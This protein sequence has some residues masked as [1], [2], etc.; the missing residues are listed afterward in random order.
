MKT[1]HIISAAVLAAAVTGCADNSKGVPVPVPGSLAQN[2]SATLRQANVNG[3]VIIRQ[4]IALPPEAVL[5][6]TLSDASVADAPSKVLAQR[7]V[8]TDGK[9]SPFQFL[10]PYSP[11][12]IKPGARI[13][14]SAAVTLN[15]KMLFIT[16]EVQPVVVN[17]VTSKDLTLVPVPSVAVPAAGG[18][19]Q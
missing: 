8:R 9:Q 14:L 11:S 18:L 1:W 12:D 6:V 17:G 7:A 16:D 15:G 3:S 10:L 13:L 19:A 4:R 2:Q 5:T